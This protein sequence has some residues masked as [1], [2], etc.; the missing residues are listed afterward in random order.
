MDVAFSAEVFS[1]VMFLLQQQEN[2]Q[3]DVATFVL[4]DVVQ[5]MEELGEVELLPGDLNVAAIV[6]HFIGNNKFVLFME[7]GQKLNY[8][9]SLLI[10]VVGLLP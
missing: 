4:L 3:K 8:V 10:F 1:V 2:E 7:K 5:D 6:M 9:V